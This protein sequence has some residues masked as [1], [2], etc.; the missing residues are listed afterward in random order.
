MRRHYPV[1][2]QKKLERMVFEMLE[3]PFKGIGKPEPLKYNL[4]GL[5]S[6]RLTDKER[7]V[8]YVEDNAI[9]ILTYLSHYSI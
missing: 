3:T 5:W 1:G 6:R 8:Y 4:T 7:V 2:V 9:N